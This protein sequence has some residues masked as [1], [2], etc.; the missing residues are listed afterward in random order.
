LGWEK[1]E[2]GGKNIAEKK[3]GRII[4]QHFFPTDFDVLHPDLPLGLQEK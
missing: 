3:L 1:V 2:I 4:F